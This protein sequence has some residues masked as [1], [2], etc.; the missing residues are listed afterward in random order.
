[1][2]RGPLR[3]DLALLLLFLVGYGWLFVFFEKLNNPNEL[4]RV[5]M[6]RAI[7]EE[8]TYAIGRRV[9]LGNRLVDT[10]PIYSDWGYVNDKALVCDDPRARPP[11][12]VGTLYAVKAPATTLLGLPVVAAL[13]ALLP[14]PPSRTQ[15]V[16]ALR[17][18][19]IILPTVL[20][21]LFVRRFL[22]A[23]GA[24]EPLALSVT[25]AAAF[26]SLSLTYGQ[27]Y[28][29][30]NL[31]AIGLGLAFLA[32]FWPRA[33]APIWPNDQETAPG[34]SEGESPSQLPIWS[35]G[36][37]SLAAAAVGFGTALAIAAE[38]PAGPACVILGLGWLWA[39]RPGL[40]RLLWA[41][42]GA[43]G[44]LFALAH[45][46][47]AAFGSLFATPYA[48]QEN[49]QF[50]QDLSQGP[51]GISPPTVERLFGSLFS[52][53]LGLF[54]WAPWTAL[55][56]FAAV[57]LRR[58]LPGLT[59]CAVAGYYL[60]FQ[61]THA[62]WRSGWVVGPRYTTPMIPCLALAVGLSLSRL[63]RVDQPLALGI[64]GGLAA[65]AVGATGLASAVC[66]GFPEEVFNP[67]REI[68]GPLLAH[69]YVPRNLLQLLGVPGLWSAL[70]YFAALALAILLLLT[71]PLR[72]DRKLPGRRLGA[73]FAVLLAAALTAAQ[74]TARSGPPHPGAVR[75][76]ASIWE[77]DPPPGAQ[78]F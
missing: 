30:H 44:P 55:I 71:A 22:R 2:N 26:G 49:A 40:R 61:I 54:Y 63:R 20:L 8:H 10:G 31:A 9:A 4:V 64:F 11:G 1:M 70:P 36:Q 73:L 15:Y 19:V 67:L 72:L 51:L 68:V 62:F 32:T 74:W 43:A 29:G 7:V 58:S 37:E 65:A 35:A 53:F 16:F 14:H 25:L 41:A 5:Y 42:L 46:Q 47:H 34:L 13:R 76:L 66:Q 45:F 12:C 48:H 17:W 33:G 24:G 56:V 39:R 21:W 38:Y 6:A 50:I 52:P 28:A 69:G 77:P 27:L 18:L 3:S 23:S 57:R 78:K 59:A 75:Y 60:V